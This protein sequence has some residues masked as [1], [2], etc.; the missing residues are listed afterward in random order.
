VGRLKAYAAN[1]ITEAICFVSMTI[2]GGACLAWW[3]AEPEIIN[4]LGATLSALGAAL[5][6]YQTAI[7][8][9]NEKI[10]TAETIN[11]EMMPPADSEVARKIIYERG[12]VRTAERIRI[13]AAIAI[14]VFVGELMHGWG[15]D[16]YRVALG[17]PDSSTN[18]TTS[19][20]VSP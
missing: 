10:K 7:E 3:L 11:S 12:R 13:I 17:A 19:K 4:R 1:P 20:G 14:I 18:S 9:R 2:M 15:D 5:V 16:L 8:V 6:L